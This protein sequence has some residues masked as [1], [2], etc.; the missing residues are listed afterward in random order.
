MKAPKNRSFSLQAINLEEANR[1]PIAFTAPARLKIG[2]GQHK[3]FSHAITDS[4]RR[5]GVRVSDG[6]YIQ[7][8]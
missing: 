1:N 7:G 3:E 5:Q 2:D 6:V 4:G 8:N